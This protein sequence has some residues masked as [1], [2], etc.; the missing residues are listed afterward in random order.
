V[1]APVVAP[2][3]VWMKPVWPG[4]SRAGLSLT[5]VLARYPEYQ[6]ELAPLLDTAY[7]LRGA[8]WPVL[9]MSARVRDR[10]RM[11]AALAQQKPKRSFLIP[12]LWWQ[13]GAALALVV[14]AAT[15]FMAWPGRRGDGDRANI[16]DATS[17]V[18]AISAPSA[19]VETIFTPTP[20]ATETETPAITPAREP[21]EQPI[22][23]VEPTR[24]PQPIPPITRTATN[25]VQPA[26]THTPSPTASPTP[27]ATNT[28]T[29]EPV[30]GAAAVVPGPTQPTP[31]DDD[32][33]PRLRTNCWRDSRRDC[34]ARAIAG[35]YALSGEDTRHAAYG[36]A[37]L[38]A[39]PGSDTGANPATLRHAGTNPDMANHAEANSGV[40]IDRTTG[41]NAEVRSNRGA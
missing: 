38:T 14:L 1:V 23:V 22:Q 21:T 12:P 20:T 2:F 29:I 18:E 7:G 6:A 32:A 36:A 40:G 27:T 35:A 37:T 39:Y 31:E 33:T 8:D 26:A 5:D 24:T 17:T 10:E 4:R 9:S 15:T 34:I 41:T 30:A 25:T 19:T 13:L 16:S 3:A 28:P 11:H